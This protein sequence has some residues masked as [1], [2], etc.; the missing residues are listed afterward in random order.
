MY[1]ADAITWPTQ[2]KD[3]WNKLVIIVILL[4]IPI[5]NFFGGIIIV[6]Y[7]LRVMLAARDDDENLPEFDWVS[8]FVNGLLALLGGLV[9][10]FIGIVISGIISFI[11]SLDLGFIGGMIVFVLG[12][13]S[14]IYSIGVSFVLPL[15]YARFARTGQF[16]AFFD[17]QDYFAMVLGN[18]GEAILFFI[19]VVLFGI[20]VGIAVVFGL[21]LCFLPGL[22][23]I[24][25]AMLAGYVL[26]ARYA[27]RMGELAT[28]GEKPKNVSI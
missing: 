26:Q 2:R 24:G 9:Y 7:G 16:S 27:I 20:V 25:I 13:I 28:F 11:S 3:F 12:I 10:F 5:V 8:D 18:L 4:I 22:I 17:I 21:L 6:G 23:M 14:L 1:F 19:N 15:A